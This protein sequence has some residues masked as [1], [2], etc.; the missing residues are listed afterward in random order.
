M[1]YDTL[2]GASAFGIENAVPPGGGHSDKQHSRGKAIILVGIF[3]FTNMDEVE[4][5]SHQQPD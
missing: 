4:F 1:S 2:H 3:G 5:A